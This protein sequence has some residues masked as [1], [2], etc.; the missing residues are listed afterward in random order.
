MQDVQHA[1]TARKELADGGELLHGIIGSERSSCGLTARPREAVG[2]VPS[3]S[4]SLRG[5]MHAVL[6]GTGTHSR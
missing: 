4:L 6:Y 1:H 5:W 3:R 2:F